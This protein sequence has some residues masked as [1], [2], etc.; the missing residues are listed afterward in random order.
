VSSPARTGREPGLDIL[1]IAGCRPNFVKLAPL[2]A[3]MERRP[4]LRPLL[5]HTGQHYDEEMSGALFRDLGLRA[6]DVSLGVGSGSHAAQTARLLAALEPVFLERAPD[7]VLVVGD[8]NSTLAAALVAVKLGIPVAHV[9]AGLRSGD[10]AMPEEVNRRVTDTLSDLLFASE[11]SGSR[12]LLSEGIPADRVHFVGNVM[13]DALR[14]SRERIAASDAVERLGL[15]PGGYAVLTLHRPENVDDPR[16]A[17]DL[18]GA[19][20]EIVR[21]VPV[22]FPVHPRTRERLRAL[23][24]WRRLEAEPALRTTPALG[25]VDFL[26]LVERS[27]LVLTDSGGLQEESTAL[28]VPCLTLRDNTERPV[29]VERGTNRLVGTASAAIVAAAREVLAA[30]RAHRDANADAGAVDGARVVPALDRPFNGAFATAATPPPELWDGHAAE[31]IADVLLDC[32]EW[33]KSLYGAL[34]DRTPWS[35][36]APVK[37]A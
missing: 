37:V 23:E 21:E 10:R 30:R 20:T 12:N 5:V 28:G 15:A 29:T 1:A 8:V 34:R 33:I 16:R 9:E 11:P 31:R 4:A 18:L 7:L 26:C 35:A 2:L 19:L 27:A 17:A 6:P 24:A 22:V 14:L 13:V 36:T 25:Y 32:E 3:A